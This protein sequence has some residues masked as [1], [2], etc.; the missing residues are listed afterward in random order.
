[1]FRITALIRVAFRPRLCRRGK[2][3]FHIA[4]EVFPFQTDEGRQP[5]P[6][7][8][9][10][11]LNE[12]A[13]EFMHKHC[14]IWLRVGEGISTSDFGFAA[15]LA[16]EIKKAGMTYKI[17]KPKKRYPITYSLPVQWV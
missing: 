13:I 15:Y 8:S 4:Y 1:M 12:R 9:I 16:A 17:G 2:P 11:P 3:D 14:D 10:D 7:W 6:D 5:K